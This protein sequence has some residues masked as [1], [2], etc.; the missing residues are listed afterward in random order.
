MK[1]QNAYFE[2]ITDSYCV[3]KLPKQ[4]VTNTYFSSIVLLFCP[5]KKDYVM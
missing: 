3:V 1:Y 2:L 4:D 5:V